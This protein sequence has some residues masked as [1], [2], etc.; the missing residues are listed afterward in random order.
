MSAMSIPSL[1]PELLDRIIDLLYDS[2]TTLRDCCLVAKSWVPR[3]R[4]H[5]FDKVIL[6]I[7][8]LRTWKEIF[9]D[10]ST[11]PARYAKTLIIACI[12]VTAA[13]G[14]VGGWIRGFSYVERLEVT[15]HLSGSR[16][17][18]P[19]LPFCGFSP[20]LKSLSVYFYF[21][22]SS[23]IF[24]LILSFPLLEDLHVTI[25][26]NGLINNNNG[27]SQPSTV[28]Q[29]PN[30][31]MTGF[32]DL[33]QCGRLGFIAGW[34]L[35]LSGGL[36]FCKLAVKC[37]RPADISLITMLVEECSHTLEYI[38]IYCIFCGMPIRYPFPHRRLISDSS[39]L[40]P[41]FD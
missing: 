37:S 27:F 1:P 38:E 17:T 4:S 5:L 36:H 16:A 9:P 21:D 3:T 25:G 2:H 24:D 40:G 33:S 32:L 18:V 30:Q 13:E 23:E 6:S 8:E 10:P 28:I 31:P 26:D 12:P 11:S 34:L 7:E 35:S 15:A 41:M 22:P 29:S 14:E 20:I 39:Q 19:L